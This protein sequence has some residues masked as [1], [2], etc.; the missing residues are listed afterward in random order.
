MVSHKWAGGGFPTLIVMQ[1]HSFT[2][3]IRWDTR[4]SKNIT[5]YWSTETGLADY[6][7]NLSITTQKDV[8]RLQSYI[9]LKFRNIRTI[10]KN[11]N[12]L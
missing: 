10:S 3:V 5:T 12:N 2:T 4:I 1:P 6:L 8:G 11:I 9:R 7:N